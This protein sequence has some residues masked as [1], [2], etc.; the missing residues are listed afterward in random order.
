M[1]KLRASCDTYAKQIATYQIDM[2]KWFT[3]FKEAS[4]QVLR[5]KNEIKDQVIIEIVNLHII[6]YIIIGIYH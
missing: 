2:E 6:N 5:L 4:K 1:A 3:K